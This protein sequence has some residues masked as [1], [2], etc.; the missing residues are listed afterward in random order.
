[1]KP[2]EHAWRLLQDHASRQLSTGFADRVLRA[3]L[4]PQAAAWEQLRAQATALLHPG[5]AEKVLRAARVAAEMPSL[6]SQCVLSALTAA[7]CL[8]A[9]LLVQHHNEQQADERNLADWQQI[10][11]VAQE[12]DSSQ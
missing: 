3:A 2:E 6:L 9:V 7:A 5:F 11:L 12:I 8:I 1:M 4:G 10:V